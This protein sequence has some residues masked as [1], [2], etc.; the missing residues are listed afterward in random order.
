GYKATT[1]ETLIKEALCHEAIYLT[2]LLGCHHATDTPRTHALAALMCLNAARFKSRVDADGDLLLL[3]D[4]D[5][6]TWDFRLIQRGLVHLGR[7]A[8]GDNLSEY[9]LQAGI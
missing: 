3:K 4:Q 7:A 8:T 5:R 1:G 2:S 9:H 6:S